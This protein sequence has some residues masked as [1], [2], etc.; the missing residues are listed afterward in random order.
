[1]LV[2]SSHRTR[3]L[4]LVFDSAVKLMAPGTVSVSMCVHKNNFQNNNKHFSTNWGKYAAED[5]NPDLL[6]FNKINI[7]TTR[8]AITLYV[9]V[10]SE[11]ESTT[12][13]TQ[14]Y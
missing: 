13:Y 3:R 9:K 1:M 2:S 4:E 11:A 10:G 7:R 8:P 12:Y 14:S 5:Q 6:N